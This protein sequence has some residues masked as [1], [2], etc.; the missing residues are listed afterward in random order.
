MRS[1]LLRRLRTLEMQ[2]CAA[3]ILPKAILPQWLLLDLID[4]GLKVDAKG[5][6]DFRTFSEIRD[7]VAA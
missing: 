2:T 3:R 5:R 4:R 6:P 7:P 1:Q